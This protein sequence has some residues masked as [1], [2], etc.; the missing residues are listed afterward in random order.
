MADAVLISLENV[1]AIGVPSQN[2]LV[3]GAVDLAVIP[4][5]ERKRFDRDTCIAVG[6]LY[7]AVT[8][9]CQEWIGFTSGTVDDF[10][11]AK[12]EIFACQKSAIVPA[13]DFHNVDE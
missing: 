11:T 12:G 13:E 4:I 8:A 3:P 7:V 6:P 5:I 2:P 9:E 10:T 1:A